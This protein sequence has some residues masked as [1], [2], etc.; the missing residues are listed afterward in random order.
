MTSH[1]FPRM[2]RIRQNFERDR[3]E[4]VPG[5]VKAELAKL[6]QT[7]KPGMTV[8]ITA[9]SR[10]IQNI[11]TILE[12]AV[13]FVKDKG[14]TP[15]LL[16]A[17]GSHG[18]GSAAGQKEV[19]DSLGITEERLGARVI[20]CDKGREVGTTEN[21][22]KVFMLESAFEVDA[23]M[24]INRVK[25]HTSFKGT[26]ESGLAKK[27]VVGLGGP[28]GATQFHAEGKSERLSPLLE[29]VA[30]A[31]IAKMPVVG[32]LALIENAYEETAKI[33]GILAKDIIERERELLRY[34][35]SLMPSLPVE[36]LDALV[37]EEMG[38][39]Y[40]GTGLDTN[41]VG[42]LR[43]QGG[44]EP[45][46]PVIHYV[47]V[48]DLS[49]ASHGNATGIGLADFTTRKLVDKIDRK[50]TYLNCLTTTFVARAFLPLFLDTEEETL[51][52]MMHCLRNTPLDE[53][54]MVCVPNTL[55]LTDC[56]VSEALIPE[57]SGKERFDIV[58]SPQEVTFDADGRL[59]LRLGAE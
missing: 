35:K 30:S 8:G 38:K 7:I 3:V 32:G 27:L 58:G 43:I 45:V 4:D 34:S 48:L 12:I 41:I 16:A 40:S 22:W 23:I 54:R 18:G 46:A 24:P 53:V 21:G 50:A 44:A 13:Q 39:N 52:T 49:E 42:R 5:T 47:S 9:G 33:E 11:L 55:Y 17:M 56:Y 51:K 36:H 59:Q 37:V 31:I 19:L 1:V 15:V 26:V 2:V 29:E 6:E 20:T 57:L 25:T 10:G 14:A 28:A